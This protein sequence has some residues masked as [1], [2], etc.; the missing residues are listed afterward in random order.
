MV[1][2]TVEQFH[3]QMRTAG[4]CAGRDGES[5]RRAGIRMAT[6][7]VV[8]HE[9]ASI[10]QV[11]DGDDAIVV[12]RNIVTA[13]SVAAAAM[14]VQSPRQR[15]GWTGRRHRYECDSASDGDCQG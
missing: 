14:R 8:R 12:R 11:R 6:T 2:A 10:E 13:D 15:D 3:L 1:G 7:R 4:M 5:E 9:G